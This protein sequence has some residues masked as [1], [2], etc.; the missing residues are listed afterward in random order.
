[1]A[2]DE[3]A[4]SALLKTPSWLLTQS[5]MHAQR[6]VGE[7]FAAGNARGY[8]YRLLATLA[9]FG[10]AS[11][12]SLGRRT[13]IDRSDVVA[14]INELTADGYVE[15]SPDPEDGRRNIITITP[16]GRRQH[17]RLD[18]LVK[19]AQATIFAPLSPAERDQLTALLAKV[20]T[21]HAGR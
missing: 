19:E 3:L 13:G 15:R 9:E 5:A 2:D 18:D 12:A 16:A 20:L 10:P 21:H 7:A 8:H 17:S 6:I 11:Q 14:A 1:M 4:P